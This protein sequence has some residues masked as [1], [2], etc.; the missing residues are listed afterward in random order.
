MPQLQKEKG[1]TYF[2]QAEWEVSS[3]L[4][5]CIQSQWYFSFF[6]VAEN[7]LCGKTKVYKSQYSS[8]ISFS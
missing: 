1:V 4:K 7:K 2:V 3:T 8:A 6:V 5:P